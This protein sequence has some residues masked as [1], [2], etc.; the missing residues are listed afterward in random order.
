M[1]TAESTSATTSNLEAAK[2]DL[3]IA[4]PAPGGK[5]EQDKEYVVVR[6]DGGWRQIR[7]HEYSDVYAIPGL[8]ERWVYDIFR[9][10]S[11]KKIRKLLEECQS[12]F[13]LEP[14]E[15][16]TLDL[17]AGNGCVAEELKHMGIST[18]VGVDIY[19]NARLAAERDRPGLY[20]DYVVGDLTNLPEDDRDRLKRHRFNCMACVAA[21]GFGDI[22]PAV[23][24][25][26][27]N[28][29]EDGGWVAFTIK[30]D[31][32][33]E[34]DTSGFSTLIRH[35]IASGTIELAAR[36]LYTHRVST[37]G[38]E[39]LYSAFVARKRNDIEG[40]DFRS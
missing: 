7:L 12:L 5:M 15:L 2:R 10:A 3:E 9:C 38:H 6:Q 11:P 37:D 14:S 19:E 8:Y 39:L 33:D 17:G 24:A 23:F 22:P 35:M 28:Y 4:L 36:E 1:T 32:V 25:E 40:F 20:D 26:A 21:L 34:R 16:R 29:V 31:F 18:F 13:G 27:F 30:R